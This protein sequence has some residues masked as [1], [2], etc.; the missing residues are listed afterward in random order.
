MKLSTVALITFVMIT[1]DYLLW[2]IIPRFIGFDEAPE[3]LLQAN[4]DS[5]ALMFFFFMLF[6]HTKES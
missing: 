3:L 1:V 6:K 4:I 2:M 5:W